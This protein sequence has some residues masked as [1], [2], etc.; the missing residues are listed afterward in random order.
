MAGATG[1]K[2][3]KKVPEESRSVF[4]FAPPNPT[5]LGGG[6]CHRMRPARVITMVESEVTL[7]ATVI[8][9]AIATPS[10]LV[11]PAGI[12]TLYFG[13]TLLE[14]WCLSPPVELPTQTVHAFPCPVPPLHLLVC[15][16]Q[17]FPFPLSL[18]FTDTAHTILLSIPM[19]PSNRGMERTL[20]LRSVT[21]LPFLGCRTV[22]SRPTVMGQ[23]LLRLSP[24][25][26]RSLVRVTLNGAL[27][28]TVLLHTRTRV[29]CTESLPTSPL[30]LASPSMRWVLLVQVKSASLFVVE[31][32]LSRW[33]L[34]SVTSHLFL[35]PMYLHMSMPR[36]LSQ[37]GSPCIMILLQGCSATL[38]LWRWSL[39][40]R[41]I[42]HA[43]ITLFAPLTVFGLVTWW[44][45][46]TPV[47]DV[48]LARFLVTST[49]LLM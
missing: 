38:L 35:K 7:S 36:R 18:Q 30:F 15:R 12:I 23:Q 2:L 31:I 14:S 43:L 26:T 29:S 6:C 5:L 25:V 8:I 13:P 10:L 40:V 28:R 45:M 1:S 17:Q 22:P 37:S 44:N 47:T 19:A 20:F 16:T 33:Q 32:K 27:S 46:L 3:A 24:R 49:R 41:D 48:F 11:G 34:S 4:G 21:L 42:A 9:L 39:L